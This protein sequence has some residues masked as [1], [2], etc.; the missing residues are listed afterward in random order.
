MALGSQK[1]FLLGLVVWIL[2]QISRF[3][4]L[5]LIGDINAGNENPAW[6]FPAY[7]DL[8]AAISA[9]PLAFAAWKLKGVET[10]SLLIIYFSIS[11]VDHMGNFVTTGLVGEPSIVP[12]GQNPI[13]FPLIMTVFD[14]FFLTLLLVPKYRTLFFE[15]EKNG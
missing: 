3:I 4:A 10:W 7:L 15:I 13:I 6:M 9:L 11:I 8:L 5:A 12:A 1:L 14:L 2:L